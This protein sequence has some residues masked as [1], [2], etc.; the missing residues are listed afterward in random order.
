M[1]I[2][3]ACI[4]EDMISCQRIEKKTM[5]ADDINFEELK[6]GSSVFTNKP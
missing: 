5:R 2:L 6:T 1:V 4:C 3:K